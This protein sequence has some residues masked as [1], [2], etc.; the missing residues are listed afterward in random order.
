MY[1][2]EL[3]LGYMLLIPVLLHKSP[4]HLLLISW[5]FRVDYESSQH[6]E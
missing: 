4:H 5:S 6:L 2:P 1:R 3:K